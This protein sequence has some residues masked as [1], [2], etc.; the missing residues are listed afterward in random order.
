M[1]LQTV[2]LW[3]GWIRYYSENWDEL[4]LRWLNWGLQLN[5]NVKLGF[6]ALY[7]GLYLVYTTWLIFYHF[8][9]IFL[10]LHSSYH[11]ACIFIH[12]MN[13]WRVL[14]RK[15]WFLKENEPSSTDLVWCIF[16]TKIYDS[17]EWFDLIHIRTGNMIFLSDFTKAV[18]RVRYMILTSFP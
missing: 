18:F 11:W 16:R 15:Y 12:I 1:T 13:Y 9:H 2:M 3:F 8:I 5:S 7:W 14:S 10:Y 17:F 4:L 6:L